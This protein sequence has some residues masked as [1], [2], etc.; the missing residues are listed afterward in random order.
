MKEL[1]DSLKENFDK[2]KIKPMT[3]ET[4]EE[5]KKVI[6][7]SKKIYLPKI[8]LDFVKAHNGFRPGYTHLILSSTG[9]GK[10]TFTRTILYEAIKNYKVLWYST[11]ETHDDFKEYCAI[12]NISNDLLKNVFFYRESEEER[13]IDFAT[14][15]LVEN[16]CDLFIFDNY[17]TC[18]EVSSLDQKGQII[19]F[20]KLRNLMI[21]LSVPLIVVAHTS[22][23]SK[24]LKVEKRDP[25]EIRG[26]KDFA[27]E[28]HVIYSL[29]TFKIETK[30]GI[31]LP[32]GKGEENPVEH[33]LYEVNT[34]SL[35]YIIKGRKKGKGKNYVLTYNDETGFYDYAEEIDDKSFFIFKK[36]GVM[37]SKGQFESDKKKKEE[38]VE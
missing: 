21:E 27:M 3:F 18:K 13:L 15:A 8:N 9:D 35:L 36:K 19:F 5:R 2:K 6:E 22:A 23:E 11:E 29:E 12:S 7:E 30:A 34:V 16:A 1:I 24:G 26:F 25:L 37:Y 10:S 17:T 38:E 4:E 14:R 20:K 31:S 33:I 32:Y 28:A